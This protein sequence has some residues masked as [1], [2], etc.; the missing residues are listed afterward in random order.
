MGFVRAIGSGGYSLWRVDTDGPEEL[1][2]DILGTALSDEKWTALSL[3]TWDRGRVIA[4][5]YNWRTGESG[6]LGFSVDPPNPPR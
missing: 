5:A 1:Q 3:L 4:A 2:S 6:I